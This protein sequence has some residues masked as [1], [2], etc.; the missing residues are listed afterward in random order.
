[1]LDEPENQFSLTRAALSKRGAQKRFPI[2]FIS[3]LL[4]GVIIP[5]YG[6]F[7]YIPGQG[8]V[9]Q[10]LT[11][12]GQRVVFSGLNLP[13]SGFVAVDPTTGDFYTADQDDL[14]VYRINRTNGVVTFVSGPGVGAG[15]AFTGH[16]YGIVVET[17]G[18][19]VVVDGI[20]GLVGV[21]RVDARTGN[22]VVLSA[23][24]NSTVP[25][26]SGVS[27]QSPFGIT[28]ESTGNFLVTDISRSA[29]IR[30][31]RVSGNRSLV[32][33][34]P[35]GDNAG[36]GPDMS[37]PKGIALKGDGT[38]FVSDSG[39]LS[40]S[41]RI[42]Q[43]NAT[44]GSRTTVFASTSYTNT[45]GSTIY[46]LSVGTNGAVIVP[47]QNTVNYHPIGGTIWGI[48][49][50]TGGAT[51]ISQSYGDSSVGT[52]P[53][54]LY[55]FGVARDRNGLLIVSDVLVRSIFVVNPKTG[56]R[57]VLQNSRTGSGIELYAPK[58]VA[59][60]TNG[61][62]VVA[63]EGNYERTVTNTSVVLRWPLL[64]QIEPSTG[65]RSVLSAGSNTGVQRGTGS[66]FDLPR[67]VA[68]E[69][70]GTFV[71]TDSGYSNPKVVRVDPATGNRTI[72]S[73]SSVGTGTVFASPYG[74]ALEN[75]GFFVVSDTGLNAIL[76][77]DPATGNRTVL[78]GAGVG[79]GPAF[80]QLR[81]VAVLQD[82]TIVATDATL[83]AVLVVNGSTGNRTV[84]SSA[85]VGT[86]PTFSS[87]CG[88]TATWQGDC[89]VVDNGTASV[90]KVNRSTGSRT[91]VS[92]A[93]V[94]SGPCVESSPEFLA[95]APPL[96]LTSL[97]RM[98]GGATQFDLW[99]PIGKQGVIEVSSN[100][101][102]WVKLTNFTTS[103]NRN[104]VLDTGAAS[105]QKRFYRAFFAP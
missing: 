95:S 3:L 89:L 72:L 71:V 20:G 19:P 64:V 9:S 75:S 78:S 94:G 51:T 16:V 90:F 21:I 17:N 32:S 24:A 47:F 40:Y 29:V 105:Q 70:A 13:T 86:G 93:S 80:T 100:L 15:P 85:N 5:V 34:D 35:F 37:G 26:G 67:G 11:E 87:P 97:R 54:F 10:V 62:V 73:S 12:S 82:G 52:G 1:M 96:A 42:L 7:A 18:N 88:I 68:C 53:G 27:F 30:V 76:R 49:P 23:G 46:G 56:N 28:I 98:V 66:N 41:E 44:N 59:L 104:T 25:M 92:S 63:D 60:G 2:S 45:G 74:I 33:G 77:V 99:S 83:G 36:S 103:S 101:T 84:L 4:G 55:P 57:N 50:T 39:G 79:A 14:A 81:G 8:R 38:I 102:T 61:V 65:N 22:R 6:D 58:G 31:D 69:N 43:I 48:T 91:V